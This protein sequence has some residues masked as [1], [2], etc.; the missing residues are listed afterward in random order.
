MVLK[1]YLFTTWKCVTVFL[2]VKR[3]YIPGFF[4]GNV[5]SMV[6]VAI[7]NANMMYLW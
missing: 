6:K 2:R 3:E 4:L 5:E 1:I 7:I